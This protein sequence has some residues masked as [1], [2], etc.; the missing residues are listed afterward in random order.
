MGTYLFENSHYV[1]RI[2]E[3]VNDVDGYIDLF[4]SEKGTAAFDVRFSSETSHTLNVVP[5]LQDHGK[6]IWMNTIAP[7]M[8]AGHDDKLALS[9]PKMAW[10]WC[11]DKGANI[12]LT[13]YPKKMA[14]YLTDSGLH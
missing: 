2:K 1:S 12:L 11:I 8:C 3:T 7:E 9:D 10:G 14:N 13:D 4:I 5:K 6:S